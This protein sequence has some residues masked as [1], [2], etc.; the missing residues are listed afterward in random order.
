MFY[1]LRQKEPEA[2]WA[3]LILDASVLLEYECAYCETNAGS[4]AMYSTPLSSRKGK[5]AFLKMFSD[6]SDGRRREDLDIPDCYPT[7]PQAEVLIFGEIPV[8][9]IKCIIFNN[10][11]TKNKYKRFIPYEVR[12]IVDNEYYYGRKDYRHWQTPSE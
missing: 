9:Y 2:E 3:I 1:S 7:N 10:E 5:N 4:E 12:A 11:S 8:D 6:N